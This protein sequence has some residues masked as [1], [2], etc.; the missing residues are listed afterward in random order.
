MLLGVDFRRRVNDVSLFSILRQFGLSLC[1]LAVCWLVAPSLVWTV[2][3]QELPEGAP[4]QTPE[5]PLVNLP[6]NPA[7][8]SAVTQAGQLRDGQR[9]ETGNEERPVGYVTY[10]TPYEV[11]LTG[12]TIV[13]LIVAI[14]A[15]TAMGWRS[16][17]TAEFTR[18]FTIVVI[19]FAALFLIAAGYSDKQAAPVY[20]LLGTIAGYIFGRMSA[21]SEKAGEPEP[22]PEAEA[23]PV[24]PPVAGGAR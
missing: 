14:A 12:L 16:G 15:L 3:A 7:P 18:T 6:D 9:I 1:L 17:L 10:K 20:G 23:R 11:W 2:R 5:R 4:V 19:V 8:V 22:E 24:V 13:V 21:T